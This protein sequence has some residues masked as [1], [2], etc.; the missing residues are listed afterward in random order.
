MC[1][2]F[3]RTSVLIFPIP[4]NMCKNSVIHNPGGSIPA[5]KKQKCCRAD[6]KKGNFCL[7]DLSIRCQLI[8]FFHRSALARCVRR[9]RIGMMILSARLTVSVPRTSGLFSPRARTQ[10]RIIQILRRFVFR[11]D[12]FSFFCIHDIGSE[13]L[14][15][16]VS[17]IIPVFTAQPSDILFF[18]LTERRCRHILSQYHRLL[19]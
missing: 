2:S 13:H 16:C 5:K 7:P 9:I 8:S 19:R 14:T 11:H 15:Q 17:D 6:Q 10:F 18:S 4:Q 1:G 3:C 12:M